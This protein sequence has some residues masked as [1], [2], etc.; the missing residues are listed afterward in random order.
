MDA[1]K[2]SKKKAVLTKLGT[3]VPSSSFIGLLQ[4][5]LMDKMD[6]DKSYTHKGAS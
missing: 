5:M 1:D 4:I 6:T 3:V 2:R